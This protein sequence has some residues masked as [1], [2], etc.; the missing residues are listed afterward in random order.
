MKED[1]NAF[2]DSIVYQGYDNPEGCLKNEKL[3]ELTKQD[4]N[5]I[6]FN[7]QKHHIIQF[8]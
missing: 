6:N 4:R 5:Q 8:V 2:R 1:M 7:D 3:F